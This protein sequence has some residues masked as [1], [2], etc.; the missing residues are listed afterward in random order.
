MARRKIPMQQMQATSM[1]SPQASSV[2]VQSN[3]EQM[4][5]FRSRVSAMTPP[6]VIDGE[7]GAM[8]AADTTMMP[9]QRRSIIN[10]AAIAT[11][12]Y[13][14]ANQYVS[15]VGEMTGN[16]AASNA[17]RNTLQ[18]IGLVSGTAIGAK[19]AFSKGAGLAGGAGGAVLGS[20]LAIAA[21]AVVGYTLALENQKMLRE[22]ENRQ[23]QSVKSS[24]RLG[25]ISSSRGR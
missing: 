16:K 5:Q 23:A 13:A 17:G 22:I 3:L 19:A 1:R 9:K 24:Q 4:N 7:P 10:T 18:T 8:T 6:T 14:V 15:N 21:I 25:Y 12:T 11:A 2:T 20:V